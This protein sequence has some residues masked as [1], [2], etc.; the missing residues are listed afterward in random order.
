[1]V[2]LFALQCIYMKKNDSSEKTHISL[3]DPCDL[4]STKFGTAG[5]LA[6]LLTHDNFLAIGLRFCF[7][8]GRIS[9]FS[10][11]QAVVVN[12]AG[13]TVQPVITTRT[14]YLAH[15]LHV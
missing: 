2:Q 15:V 5:P 13:A 1:M 8:E 11:L 6:H 9:A 12:S 14:F 7:C 3:E 10:H 4:I